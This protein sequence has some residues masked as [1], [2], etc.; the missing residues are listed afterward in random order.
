[1][2]LTDEELNELEQ[3][4]RCNVAADRRL[5]QTDH[6]EIVAELR[7]EIERERRSGSEPTRAA[8]MDGGGHPI[9]DGTESE[10]DQYGATA[11]DAAS[12]AWGGHGSLEDQGLDQTAR[13][14]N[15]TLS[16]HTPMSPPDTASSSATNSVEVDRHAMHMQMLLRRQQMQRIHQ[17]YESVIAR[18]ALRNEAAA[19][20]AR[21]QTAAAKASS[22]NPPLPTSVP[23]D[24]LIPEN[25][26]KS[27]PPQQST[28]STNDPFQQ[29]MQRQMSYSLAANPYSGLLS[30]DGSNSNRQSRNS[31]PAAQTASTPSMQQHQ[32]VLLSHQQQQQLTSPILGWAEAVLLHFGPPT[33]EPLTEQTHLHTSS[34]NPTNWGAGS[35][36]KVG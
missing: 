33:S 17:L 25:P 4:A 29:L 15:D 2:D 36:S 7:R 6:D 22:S 19:S 28:S 21:T 31:P 18:Q 20:S 9:M 26:V 16:G 10:R 14:N 35:A 12:A 11:S 30:L 27:P 13:A 34:N 3:L 24:T 5:L 1:M 8:P 23:S 32:P